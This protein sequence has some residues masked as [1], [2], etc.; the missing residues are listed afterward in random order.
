MIGKTHEKEL[1]PYGFIQ[2][3]KQQNRH[4]GN[5]EKMFVTLIE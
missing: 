3:G 5:S 1:K 2:C 4:K